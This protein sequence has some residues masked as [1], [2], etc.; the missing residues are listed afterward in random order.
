MMYLLFLLWFLLGCFWLFKSGPA[1]RLGL[2]SWVITLLFVCKVWAALFYGWFFRQMDDYAV[3]ADTWAMHYAAREETKWL[4]QEPM[5]FFTD[6]YTPRYA[7]DGGLMATENSLFND[8][9]QVIFIKLLALVNLVTGQYYVVN[10]V[11]FSIIC[12]M[13]LLHLVEFFTRYLGKAALV[14][15][16]GALF[17]F[18]TILFWTSGMHKDGLLLAISGWLLWGWNNSRRQ[19]W[20]WPLWIIC[21]VIFFLLRVHVFILFFLCF[22]PISLKWPVYKIRPAF[23]LYT[24]VFLTLVSVILLWVYN[25]VVP[26]SWL[27]ARRADFLLLTASDVVSS[28]V[29][30]PNFRG[31]LSFLPQA[32][33][34]GFLWPLPGMYSSPFAML[35]GVENAVILLLAIAAVYVGRRRKYVHLHTAVLLA[36]F[37]YVITNFLLIGY[38]IPYLSPLMRYKSIVLPF[39]VIPSLVIAMNDRMNLLQLYITNTPLVYT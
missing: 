4:L 33:A 3:K 39:M 16:L 23:K 2:K 14:A 17:C 36:C 29:F 12:F 38:T 7:D 30:T 11:V 19:A 15:S 25:P 26:A 6:V 32:A 20:Q 5:A 13:G 34:Y 37:L 9:K 22:F 27:A 21:M 18:P 31:I 24:L 28:T 35:A 1:K 10:V 8:L